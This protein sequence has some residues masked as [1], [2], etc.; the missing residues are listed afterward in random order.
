[1]RIIK[2]QHF[3]PA[4]LL[5]GLLLGLSSCGSVPSAPGSPPG[6][7]PDRVQIEI[8]RHLP[9]QGKSVVTLTVGS[10]VQQ[11]YATI[12][13]LPLMPERQPCTMELGPHYT[14]TFYQGQKTLVAALA[15]NDGCRRVSLS[16]EQHD[17]TAMNNKAFWDQLDSAIREATGAARVA[18]CL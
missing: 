3:F 6:S 1:M 2:G 5:V 13:A 8:D 7:K 4:L 15:E 14:L 16:G 17:R 12:Y 9:S 11:L 10:Q 18:G